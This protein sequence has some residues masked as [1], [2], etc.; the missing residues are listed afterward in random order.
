MS[1]ET[2][3]NHNYDFITANHVS[4]G[5]FYASTG[6]IG[7]T[8][9]STGGFSASRLN[10]GY[11]GVTGAINAP[12]ATGAI[13]SLTVAGALTAGSVSAGP[14]TAGA[15]T[16]GA[17]SATSSTVSGASSVGGALTVTSASQLN[18]GANV[19][20]N[21]DVTGTNPNFSGFVTAN[22]LL[23][24]ALFLRSPSPITDLFEATSV[25]TFNVTAGADASY[26]VPFGRTVTSPAVIPTVFV[27]GGSPALCAYNMRAVNNTS[28]EIVLRNIT[29]SSQNV[30][31]TI[32]ILVLGR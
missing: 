20:G 4:V 14:V 11:L 5:A 6:S 31:L 15:V 25:V 32:V 13:G 19:F 3:D 29:A 27:P 9:F 22:R 2:E 24:Q 7:G 30:Q 10:M 12:A 23:T 8:V 26:T 28:C 1:F 18:G 16:A 21:L 17:V